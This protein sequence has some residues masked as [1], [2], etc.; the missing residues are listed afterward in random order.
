MKWGKGVRIVPN[1]ELL[2]VEGRSKTRLTIFRRDKN[3]VSKGLR[4]RDGA[5][6][7]PIGEQ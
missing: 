7:T 5:E 6:I 4:V 1:E 2:R 3:E